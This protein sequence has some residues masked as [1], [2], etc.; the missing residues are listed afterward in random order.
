MT[1]VLFDLD[2]TLI[3][4][5]GVAEASWRLVCEQLAPG[6]GVETDVLLAELLT[7]RAWFWSLEARSREGRR[8]PRW[9]RGV[10]AARAMEALGLEGRDVDLLVDGYERARE[11]SAHA[12]PGA[13]EALR[14]LRKEGAALGLVTNG[15][16]RAQRTKLSRFELADYFDYIFIEGERGSAKPSQS[17]FL[18][19]TN[20]LG[21]KPG[22]AW[23]VGDDPVRDIAG[24]NAAGLRTIWVNP[25]GRPFPDGLETGRV[26]TSVR[27]VPPL[28]KR[29]REAR[30]G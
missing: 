13:V 18:E 26:V 10:V 23:M 21:A 1:V 16:A 8:C 29:Y 19:P 14:A 22:E 20:A 15:E 17:C 28:I 4:Y 27:E 11:A 5:N 9:A 24:A 7:Q 6:F 12:V 30:G 25:T 3:V 2:D